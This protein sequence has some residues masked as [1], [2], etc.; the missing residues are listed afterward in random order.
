VAQNRQEE[1]V[2]DQREV[3]K[4]L[5]HQVV[6]DLEQKVLVVTAEKQ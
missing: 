6:A 2:R 4:D 3:V 1:R 5:H